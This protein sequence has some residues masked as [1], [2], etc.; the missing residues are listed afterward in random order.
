MSGSGRLAGRVALVTGAAKGLGAGIARRLADEGASVICA[1]V[2]DAG[3][4]VA[5]LPGPGHEAVVLDVSCTSDVERIVA[6]VLERRGQIDILVNNAAILHPIRP[7][8]DL[9][10]AAIE[11][12][13]AVNVCGTIACSRAV[14]RT[15]RNR[16]SGRII[17]ISSQVGRAPWPGHAAYSASKAAV[18]ALTQA[19]ALELASSNVLVNC[20]CPGTMDTDQ[21]RGGFADRANAAGRDP[22]EMIGEKAASMPLGRLGTPRDAG[23]MVAFLASDDASFS[24]GAI[25]NLTGGEAVAL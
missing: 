2:L 17:N 21:M 15:M 8:L 23:A 22:E 3:P 24:T 18:I 25:F 10:E 14:G 9:D 11:R 16:G 20:V 13:F 1:D 6:D 7:L 4:V 5:A 12:V 19:M